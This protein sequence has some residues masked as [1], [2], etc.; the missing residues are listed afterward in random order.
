MKVVVRAKGIFCENGDAGLVNIKGTLTVKQVSRTSP[1]IERF[2][3]KMYS[4][5]DG[6]QTASG[7]DAR[8]ITLAV[9]DLLI[10]FAN[11]SLD[12][13][14]P[15]PGFEPGDKLTGTYSEALGPSL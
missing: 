11:F 4:T 10:F 9:G 5:L 6:H 12:L 8:P 2:D 1:P 14:T 13:R 7:V 15:V 3:A